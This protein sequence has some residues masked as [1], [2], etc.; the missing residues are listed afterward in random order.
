MFKYQQPQIQLHL[1]LTRNIQKGRGSTYCEDVYVR[2]M[3]A[4]KN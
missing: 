2:K 4:M 3:K 1:T